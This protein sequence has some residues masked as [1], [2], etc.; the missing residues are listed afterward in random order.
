MTA[1]E[2]V[3][4]P[5]LEM[6]ATEEVETE[7]DRAII[8][9]QEEITEE[10]TEEILLEIETEPTTDTDIFLTETLVGTITDGTIQ[11][12]SGEIFQIVISIT[13]DG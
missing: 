12:V 1:T 13:I 8:I 7:T 11:E 6:T 10:I 5:T 4:T 3:E 9:I 2:E